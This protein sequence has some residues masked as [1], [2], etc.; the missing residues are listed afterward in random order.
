MSES[1][2]AFKGDSAARSK[3]VTFT[4][5]LRPLCPYYSR[6]VGAAPRPPVLC[7]F[8]DDDHDVLAA[9]DRVAIGVHAGGLVLLALL[10]ESEHLGR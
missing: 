4:I 2:S 10:D 8:L 3:L 5:C 6:V 9:D 7:S 1:L